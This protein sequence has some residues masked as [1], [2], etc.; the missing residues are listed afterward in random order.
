MQD[1]ISRRDFLKTLAVTAVGLSASETIYGK[2]PLFANKSTKVHLDDRPNII[3]L[4]A[5]DQ[6]WDTMGCYGN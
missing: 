2:G 3:F 5:D 4:L 6:R 1:L